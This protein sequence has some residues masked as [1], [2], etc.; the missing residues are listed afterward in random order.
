M[1][2]SILTYVLIN[3]A[4][5]SGLGLKLWET[6]LAAVFEEGGFV[7]RLLL[8]KEKH[9]LT[10]LAR[11]LTSAHRL[12]KINL[13]VLGGDGTLGEVLEGIEDFSRVCLGYIPIGSSNDFARA[14]GQTDPVETARAIVRGRG[15]HACDL[16]ELTWLDEADGKEKKRYFLV[17]AGFGFDAA[18]CE[19]ADHSRMKKL[20]NR[21]H[22]GK[23][24]YIFSAFRLILTSRLTPVEV[25]VR[26]DL[27]MGG[28]TPAEE[29][30]SFRRTLFAVC[31]NHRY[32]GGGFM[33]CPQA[34]G[35][36]GKLDLCVAADITRLKFFFLFPTAYDGRHT[37]LKG[38][39]I[40][41]GTSM[42]FRSEVPL[43]FHTDGE[44]TGKT[45]RM[46][47]RVRRGVLRFWNEFSEL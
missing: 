17:S 2:R 7:C 32:E 10:A 31:M 4:S 40:R 47:A 29:T 45:T 5:R 42:L 34:D 16:G 41:Q 13:I 20:L 35:T 9:G 19:A 27:P 25:C 36:D 28:T 8:S 18:A 38:I 15:L 3:P 6:Q 30:L 44:V 37:R 1:D 24:I 46:E 43:F 33:F 26:Q 22:M 23:L 12:E 21:V 39:T 14:I 11:D